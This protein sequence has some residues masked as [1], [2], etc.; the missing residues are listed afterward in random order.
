MLHKILAKIVLTNGEKSHS[1]TTKLLIMRLIN[2]W[3]WLL[4]I[5]HA[6]FLMARVAPKHQLIDFG[7]QLIYFFD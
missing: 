2:N 5:S 1:L 4:A 7:D 3:Y 6:L